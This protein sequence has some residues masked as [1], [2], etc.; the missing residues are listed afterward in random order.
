MPRI[1]AGS[2]GRPGLALNVL[3]WGGRLVSAQVARGENFERE[4]CSKKKLT[5]SRWFERLPAHTNKK[6]FIMRTKTLLLTAALAA[7]GLTSSMAQVFSV[8][9]VGFVNVTVP[10]SSFALLANPLN[11]PTNDLAS[12]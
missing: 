1:R 11:Q 10:A 9:A 12:V 4:K 8:N 7:A 5:L 2:I 3:W 6:L